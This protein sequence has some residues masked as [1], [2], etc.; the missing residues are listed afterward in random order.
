MLVVTANW[1]FGDGTLAPAASA[2]RVAAWLQAVHRAATRGGFRRDGSY[3][4]V[5]ALQ[6]VLAGDTF[7]CLTSSEWTAALRP[8][9]AGRAAES[10]RRRVLLHSARRGRRMLAA[11]SRWAR[12]GLDVPAADQRGRPVLGKKAHVAVR[13]ALLTGDRDSWLHEGGDEATRHSLSLGHVWSDDTATV[14]HGAECDPCADAAESRWFGGCGWQP[15]LAESVAVDLVARFGAAV[16][17]AGPVAAGRGLVARLAAHGPLE[18][19]TVLCRW[20]DSVATAAE[21]DALRDSVLAHW[22]RSVAAWHRE[23][24]REP[25]AC[26]AGFAVYDALAELFDGV[27]RDRTRYTVSGVVERLAPRPAA[28]PGGHTVLGHGS[29]VDARDPAAERLICLAADGLAAWHGVPRTVARRDDGRGPAW[30]WLQFP[31]LA[32]PRVVDFPR[33]AAVTIVDAA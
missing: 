31:G 24:L 29:A 2:P 23:T 14:S 26:A 10:A 16:I 13:V 8:W 3:R 27:G 19:V 32:E 25:P 9:H 7:D 17:A 30:E 21:G 5:E 22:Q 33:T 20:L 12:E 1:L 28:G 15:T 6:I 18:I 4:P 11:L